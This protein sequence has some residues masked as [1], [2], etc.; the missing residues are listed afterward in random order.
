MGR[1]TSEVTNLLADGG[2][3]NEIKRRLTC[4]EDC[5]Q[6]A[7]ARRRS[8]PAGSHSV[9]RTATFLTKWHKRKLLCALCLL[10]VSEC[11]VRS[12]NPQSGTA[13]QSQPRAAMFLLLQLGNPAS[14]RRGAG[15]PLCSVAKRERR[16]PAQR[17]E[18]VGVA[19][20]TGSETF[21]TRLLG[22]DMTVRLAEQTVCHACLGQNVTLRGRGC[23]SLMDPFASLKHCLRNC[24]WDTHVF[25]KTA[26]AMRL[27][28]LA[29]TTACPET[30][31]TLLP[32]TKIQSRIARNAPP[33]PS[34]LHRLG[35]QPVW[36]ALALAASVATCFG[37]WNCAAPG[38]R[39]AKE[40]P[41]ESGKYWNMSST[42]L[43]SV[44]SAAMFA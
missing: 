19:A 10:V 34:T 42:K 21:G 24:E 27:V 29:L 33:S 38:A 4:L 39:V 32:F 22:C 36:H 13:V 28:R 8:G 7:K 1:P 14:H 18:A 23:G 30:G 12:P 3:G 41:L 25:Q 37:K 31:G 9:I 6:A 11:V 43:N 35:S 20:V 16:G 2:S 44:K 17:E 5:A 26:A 40:L 15:S